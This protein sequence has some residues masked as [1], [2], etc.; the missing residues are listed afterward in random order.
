MISRD[1]H[2]IKSGTVSEIFLDLW[3]AEIRS[4]IVECYLVQWRAEVL[5]LAP[6]SRGEAAVVW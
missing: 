1:F 3:G 5:A 4:V 2:A 6:L